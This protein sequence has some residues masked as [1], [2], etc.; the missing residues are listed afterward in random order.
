M[1]NPQ[2]LWIAKQMTICSGFA[3]LICCLDC[4]AED[5]NWESMF[6]LGMWMISLWLWSGTLFRELDYSQLLPIYNALMDES[7]AAFNRGDQWL[8]EN[9]LLQ[10]SEVLDRMQK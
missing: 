9:K 6:L 5:W 8:A 3:I 4:W 7:I 1:N 10:A 2:R